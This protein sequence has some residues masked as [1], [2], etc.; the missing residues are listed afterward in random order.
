MNIK[1]IIH[2][3]LA[4]SIMSFSACSQKEDI[5]P[6]LV[7][8]AINASFNVSNARTRVN[9][10][11]E[12]ANKWEDGDQINVSIV[13]SNGKLKK[14]VLTA[15]VSDEKTT[16]SH[17][18]NFVWN[19]MGEHHIYVSYPSSDYW[20]FTLPG[21]QNTI[22]GLKRAD[23]INGFWS[24]FPENYIDISV[25]HRM[26]RVTVKYVLGTADFEGVTLE[27][28]TVLSS[29][30]GAMFDQEGNLNVDGAPVPVQAYKHEDDNKFSAIIVPGTLGTDVEFLTFSIGEKNYVSRLKSSTD[31][32]EGHL[33]E[34]ELK[35]GKNKVELT[36]ITDDDFKFPGGWTTEEELK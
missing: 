21:E 22:E 23:L 9:T 6:S 26:A 30:S 11:D 36:R 35:V 28:P 18:K 10:L 17:H 3:G 1:N 24:K 14:C 15:S 8:Q 16:W 4:L 25:K 12:Y 34:Y 13:P 19:D 29:H 7:G 20:S 31:F 5:T 27:K 2:T 32:E 33:Y